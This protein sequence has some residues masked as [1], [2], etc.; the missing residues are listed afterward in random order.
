MINFHTQI[1][2][3]KMTNAYGR[4]SY[5]DGILPENFCVKSSGSTLPAG[6]CAGHEVSP[7]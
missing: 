3:N 4:S 7:H 5:S 1:R 2:K 6:S